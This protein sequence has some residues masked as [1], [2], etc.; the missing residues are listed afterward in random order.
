MTIEKMFRETSG[1][2][3]Y[4]NDTVVGIYN[5]IPIEGPARFGIY[6]FS[7]CDEYECLHEGWFVET[8]KI[9]GYTGANNGVP[10]FLLKNIRVV[11][12]DK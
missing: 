7:L 12:V 6:N 3:V 5:G 8:R 4:E 11:G 2:R 9:Q 10:L 1:F